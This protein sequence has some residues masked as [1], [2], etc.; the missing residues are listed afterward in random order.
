MHPAGPS[1]IRFRLRA[2]LSFCSSPQAQPVVQVVSVFFYF[3]IHETTLVPIFL[4][5]IDVKLPRLKKRKR[6]HKKKPLFLFTT[7]SVSQKLT[8]FFTRGYS[9]LKFGD[10]SRRQFEDASFFTGAAKN[11][12][13]GVDSK[14]FPDLP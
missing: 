8:I 6:G 12:G 11:T 2:P 13:V 14:K 3:A 10:D 9:N 7:L 1:V 5:K 4:T